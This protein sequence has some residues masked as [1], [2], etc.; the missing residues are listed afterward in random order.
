MITCI[1]YIATVPNVKLSKDKKI[2]FFAET[3]HAFGRSALV[4]SGK[5]EH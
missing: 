5:D 3:R 1:E 2:E 4:L